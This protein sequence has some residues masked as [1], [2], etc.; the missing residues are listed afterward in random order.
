MTEKETSELLRAVDRLNNARYL[1]EAIRIAAETLPHEQAN[2]MAELADTAVR[3]LEKVRDQID[4]SIAAPVRSTQAA[5]VQDSRRNWAESLLAKFDGP[6]PEATD[7]GILEAK[8]RLDGVRTGLNELDLNFEEEQ[9]YGEP[10]LEAEADLLQ[11]IED[12]PA[13]GFAGAA[14]KLREFLI[15]NQSDGRLILIELVYQVAEMLETRA[16]RT[17]GDAI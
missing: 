7:A 1:V 12:T 15:N 10:L 5:A 4:R 8:R 9:E 14:V 6:M 13:R 2:P 11:F 16:A 3:R 17:P